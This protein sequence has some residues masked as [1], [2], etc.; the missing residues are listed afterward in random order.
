MR[1]HAPL[2]ACLSPAGSSGGRGAALLESQLALALAARDA[3]GEQLLRA[4]ESRDAAAVAVA[5]CAGLRRQ[6]S[7]LQVSAGDGRDLRGGGAAA[8]PLRG[9]ALGRAPHNKP[10]RQQL[11]AC[12]AAGAGAA[13]AGAGGAGGAGRGG[14]GAGGGRRR[15]AA[16]LQGDP[17]GGCG[18]AGGGPGGGDGGG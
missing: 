6:L 2:P 7:E 15:G 5:E 10:L 1:R 8:A 17:G 3:A 13:R 16:H 4:L 11:S 14:G 18:A 12:A 9:A